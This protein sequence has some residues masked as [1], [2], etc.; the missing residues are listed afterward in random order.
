MTDIQNLN[1]NS[2]KPVTTSAVDTM[3][4]T[5]PVAAPLKQTSI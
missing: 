3:T 1:I 5:A 4:A 2:Q